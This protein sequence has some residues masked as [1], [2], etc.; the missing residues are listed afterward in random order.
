MS[1]DT[2]FE[3]ENV[4]AQMREN[5]TLVGEHHHC[6]IDFPDGDRGV[7][8]ENFTTGKLRIAIADFPVVKSSCR[9]E[10]NFW[11]FIV[12]QSHGSQFF[13]RSGG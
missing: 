7:R 10:L 12:F 9:I 2:A 6:E 8:Q 11:R 1:C 13:V 5:A 4:N 3:S